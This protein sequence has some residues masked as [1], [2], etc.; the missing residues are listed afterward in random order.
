MCLSFL[1]CFSFVAVDDVQIRMALPDVFASERQKKIAIG[2][3]NLL[4]SPIVIGKQGD[5]LMF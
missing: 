2:L 5:C 3:Q 4:S 1:L